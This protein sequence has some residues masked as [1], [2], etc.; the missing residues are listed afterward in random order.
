VALKPNKSGVYSIRNEEEAKQALE[1]FQSQKVEM[2]E[3]RQESGL[4]EMEN[5]SVELKK[6]VTQ[7]AIKSGAE[8]IECNGFHATLI[9]QFYDAQ[10]IATDGDIPAE[11]PEGRKLSSFQSII[12]KKFKS[13]VATKG[14]QAR[15]IWMKAT[16]RVL[17]KDAVEQLVADDVISVDELAPC[18]YEK[19]KTPFLRIFED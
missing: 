5:D 12:E 18:F 17:D 16:K 13:K 11:P 2:E 19:T 7:W 6:A 4:A 14:S 1:L 15:R 3:I 9:S 8:R 10:Y